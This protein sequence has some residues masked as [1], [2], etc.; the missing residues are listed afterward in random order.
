MTQPPYAIAAGV[1]V[2]ARVQAAVDGKNQEFSCED[3]PWNETEEGRRANSISTLTFLIFGLVTTAMLGTP[4][5]VATNDAVWL[6]L[7]PL[8]LL[9]INIAG[10]LFWGES[11]TGWIAARVFGVAVAP[12]KYLR[13][14]IASGAVVPSSDWYADFALRGE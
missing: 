14:A 10:I 2:P 1:K 9:V 11:L 12:T 3:V 5:V 4:L 8:A 13:A 7:P 6:V